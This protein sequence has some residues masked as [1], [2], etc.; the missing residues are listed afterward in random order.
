MIQA[1]EVTVSW[2][3][4]VEVADAYVG[5][6]VFFSLFCSGMGGLGSCMIVDFL[7]CNWNLLW[8][9]LRE[10]FWKQLLFFFF[11]VHQESHD[12][13]ND[14]NLLVV[15]KWRILTEVSLLACLIISR[16]EN[17]RA[18]DSLVLFSLCPSHCQSLVPWFYFRRSAIMTN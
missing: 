12:C 8:V 2:V 11:V 7:C 10:T 9:L 3:S 5:W 18:S 15:M 14:S 1:E 6:A 4:M 13:S 16:W 17:V